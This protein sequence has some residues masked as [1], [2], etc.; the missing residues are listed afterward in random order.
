MDGLLEAKPRDEPLDPANLADDDLEALELEV[1]MLADARALDEA[2]LATFR[3]K[4]RHVD[5]VLA[6]TDPA[7]RHA[8]VDGD[9]RTRSGRLLPVLR[10]L[11]FEMQAGVPV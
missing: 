6:L 2:H 4:V 9:A 3:R 11:A 7:K 1:H 8:H 5:L 10:F